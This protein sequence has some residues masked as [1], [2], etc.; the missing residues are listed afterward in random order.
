LKH[1]RPVLKKEIR[2]NLEMLEKHDDSMLFRIFTKVNQKD[3]GDHEELVPSKEPLPNHEDMKVIDYPQDIPTKDELDDNKVDLISLVPEGF[4]KL[5]Y[6][7]Q[8]IQKKNSLTEF[9]NKLNTVYHDRKEIA[10]GDNYKVYNVLTL[11]I[12]DTNALVL[13][14]SLKI[15]ELLAKLKD[16][17]LKGKYAMT[18]TKILFDRF[19]ETKTAVLTTIKNALD[20]LIQNEIIPVNT[21][22]DI[23]LTLDP[24]KTKS[25]IVSNSKSKGVNPRSKQVSFNPKQIVKKLV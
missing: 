9:Y 12:E 22:I 13:L 15:I 23:A 4:D 24:N 21:M 19:K 14:E 1:L 8:V 6:V 11:L 18:Y 20:A 7:Q 2:T 3:S 17:G 16:N 25:V 10:K 5:S